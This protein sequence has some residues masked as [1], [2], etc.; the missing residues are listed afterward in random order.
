[1]E[2]RLDSGW[3]ETSSTRRKEGRADYSQERVV[4]N[5]ESKL[6]EVDWNPT[7]STWIGGKRPWNMLVINFKWGLGGWPA[8]V[9]KLF[10]TS[11]RKRK[12]EHLNMIGRVSNATVVCTHKRRRPVFTTWRLS[13]IPQRRIHKIPNLPQTTSL[14]VHLTCKLLILETHFIKLYLSTLNVNVGP[15]GSLAIRKCTLLASVKVKTMIWV[16]PRG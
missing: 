13:E 6:A 11:C 15:V 5:V 12:I 8:G 10:M 9:W 3:Y 14:S 1:M 4:S 16:T 2:M 7:F